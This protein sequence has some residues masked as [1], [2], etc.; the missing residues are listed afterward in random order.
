GLSV[1]DLYSL[2]DRVRWLAYS[3]MVIAENGKLLETAKR[4][5]LLYEEIDSHFTKR[6]GEINGNR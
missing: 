3:V 2:L 6:D 1:G 4:A 5:Q